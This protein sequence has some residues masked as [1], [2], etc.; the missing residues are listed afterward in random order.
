MVNEDD[1][2]DLHGDGILEIDHV[3]VRSKGLFCF[4]CLILRIYV[5]HWIVS[6]MRAETRFVIDT[7]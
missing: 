6:F 3:Q 1:F 7:A 2:T 4:N 5:P